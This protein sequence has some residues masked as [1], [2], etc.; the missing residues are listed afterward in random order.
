[1][2]KKIIAVVGGTGAQGGG[3]VDHLLERGRFAV[4]VLTRNPESEQAKALA[5][6]G[7]EV[8]AADL[9]A[10]ESLGPAFAGAHGAF[11][12]T[13]FW[14]PKTGTSELVQGKAA[15]AAAKKAGVQ[16][17]VWSTLPN[18][19]AISGGALAVEHF[20]GKALV[21]P[22]VSNAGFAHHTFVEAPMY[23]QNL[24]GMM[25]PQPGEDGK[26]AWSLPMD[27]DKKCIHVGDVSEMGKLVARVFEEPALVGQGQHLSLASGMVSWT[28]MIDTLNAQ[29]HDLK[30][31][32]VP[33][34]VFDGFF[35][36]AAELREMFEYF[37]AHTYFGPDRETKIALANEIVP[38]GFT[39]FAAWAA[40]NMKA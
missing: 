24:T 12:V 7:C 1:M 25:A 4:R 27:P 36:G 5:A 3:V 34:D 6:R 31:N 15:A 30:Y 37:E 17:Y 18:S 35:P 23:F 2:T 16:H 26:K 10:P 28:E 32:R 8:V 11:V 20:T 39:P 21:D 22:E 9:N 13:N 19:K 29:G 38:D 14:D 33:A 40:E